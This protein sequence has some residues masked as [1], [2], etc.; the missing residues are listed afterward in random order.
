M[1]HAAWSMDVKIEGQNVIRHMDLTTHNHINNPNIALVLNQAKQ[2]MEM[3]GDLVAMISQ[4]RMITQEREHVK[5]GKR[6][7]D[8]NFSRV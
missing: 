3:L 4:G 1:K 6:R 7:R 5:D 8:R 2:N